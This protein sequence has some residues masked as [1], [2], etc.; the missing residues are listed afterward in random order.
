MYCRKCG[1][2]IPDGSAFCP[3][4]GTPANDKPAVRHSGLVC[5][6]CGSVNVDIQLHQEEKGSRTVTK[7]KSTY[8]E[9]RHGLFWW[10]FIGWWWWIIDL[11]LWIC[12]FPFKFIA[13]ITKKRKFKGTSS[14]VS[15][16]RNSIAYRSMCLCKNCGYNWEK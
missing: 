10:M 2:E 7:T 1:K 3:E 16:T 6:K 15:K 4:C 9:K 14:S 11:M 5:P 13:A 12:F 8:K